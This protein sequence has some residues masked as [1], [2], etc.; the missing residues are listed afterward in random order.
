MQ[1][2]SELSDSRFGVVVVTVDNQRAQWLIFA[3]RALS[4]VVGDGEHRV[5][6]LLVDL[7]SAADPTGPLTHFQMKTATRDGVRD[8]VRSLAASLVDVSAV[9]ARKAGD[10]RTELGLR[11]WDTVHLATA[12]LAN[13]DVL[14]VRD[15]KIPE[16]NYERVYATGPFDL[17]E[18]K[19]F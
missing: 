8:L 13:V 7:D 15:H 19:L 17:D 14:A 12:I 4:K 9:V 6:P 11:T 5:V 10:L 18:D 2:E 3:A 16:G 1:V